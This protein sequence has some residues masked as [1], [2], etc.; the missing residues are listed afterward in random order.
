[1]IWHDFAPPQLNTRVSSLCRAVKQS[2]S[3]YSKTTSS[4]ILIFKCGIGQI[5]E[6]DKLAP[7]SLPPINKKG[8]S[9]QWINHN[10][11]G[12]FESLYV[13]ELSVIS[14]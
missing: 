7:P 9:G 14:Y 11:N 3:S 5:L 8:G 12:I 10:H 13:V 4:I 2:M 1:L 6:M